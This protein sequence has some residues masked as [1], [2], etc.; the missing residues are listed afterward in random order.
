MNYDVIAISESALHSDTDDND[1]LLD[2]YISFRRDLPDDRQYGGILVY[3]KNSIACQERRD[4]ETIS[5]QLILEL[6]VDKKSIFVSSNYRKHHHNNENEL[7]LYMDNFRSSCEN[8]RAQNPF[9]TVHIGDFNSHNSIWLN[10][11]QT[12]SAGDLLNEIINDEALAQLVDQPTHITSNCNTLIDLVITDQP[13]IVNK[14][15]ILPSL[16]PR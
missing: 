9:C 5:D 6:T 3:V 14:C 16:D 10:T 13:N 11:D 8:I 12:D 7:S 1:L 15:S 2:G 4:L